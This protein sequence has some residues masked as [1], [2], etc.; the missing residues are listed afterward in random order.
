MPSAATSTTAK[1]TCQRESLNSCQG[2]FKSIRTLFGL[3][4][5]EERPECAGRVLHDVERQPRILTE[6]LHNALGDPARIRRVIGMIPGPLCGE[7]D[8]DI[9]EI[10]TGDLLFRL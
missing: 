5:A 10:Q 9:D 2:S 3:A 7:G 8:A 4:A 1:A 6:P